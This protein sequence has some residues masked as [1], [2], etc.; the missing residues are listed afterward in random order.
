MGSSITQTSNEVKRAIEDIKNILHQG[1][2][3]QTKP[4]PMLAVKI[5]GE[6]TEEQEKV[7]QLRNAKQ[8]SFASI[9]QELNLSQKEVHQEFMLAYKMM[10]KKHEQQQSA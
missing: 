1:S 5:Q 7:L 3:L 8:Y 2:N 4:K 6:M 10:Q 9:A